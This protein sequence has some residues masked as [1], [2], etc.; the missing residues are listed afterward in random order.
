MLR[1]KGREMTVRRRK[2]TLTTTVA[3]EVTVIRNPPTSDKE[4]SCVECAGQA[5]MVTLAEAVH[6]ANINSRGIF[7]L[8]EEER[9]HFLEMPNG[10]VFICPASLL[11]QSAKRRLSDNR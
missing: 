3:H 1:L 6:M 11:K 5:R 9:I 4:A 8:I 2:T 10:E 7:R